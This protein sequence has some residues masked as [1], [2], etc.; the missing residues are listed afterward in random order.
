MQRHY[1]QG[2]VLDMRDNTIEGIWVRI[3][4][5]LHHFLSEIEYT[6]TDQNGRYLIH[7]DHGSPITIRYDDRRFS[8]GLDHV[9]PAIIGG[10][11]GAL[12]HNINKVMYWVGV[13]Y[14]QGEILDILSTY[15][16]IRF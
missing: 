14:T 2:Q 15:E 1:V 3:Y 4:R 9:H 13:G 5:K 8:S 12:D 11:S 10:V 16:R 7:F 6:L